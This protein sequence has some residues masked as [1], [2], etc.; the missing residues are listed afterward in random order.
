MGCA[1]HYDG[2]G[3]SYE[4]EMSNGSYGNTSTKALTAVSQVIWHKNNI[5]EI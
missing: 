3:L 1:N 4:P 5:G 2:F